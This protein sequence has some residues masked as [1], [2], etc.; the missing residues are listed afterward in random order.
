M[1][2]SYAYLSGITQA[3]I[4][5]DLVAILTGTT[6]TSLLSAGCDKP[7]TSILTTYAAAGWTVHDAAAG[8]NKQCLKA[9]CAHGAIDKYVT[10]D[11]NTAG[12]VIIRPYQTW[13]NVAHTGTG[14]SSATY[15]ASTYHQRYNTAGVG[16]MHISATAA[17]ILLFGVYAATSGSVSSADAFTGVIELS[18]MPWQTVASGLLPVILRPSST[19]ASTV[20][21]LP[22]KRADGTLITAPTTA[23][24]KDEGGVIDASNPSCYATLS[25]SGNKILMM[26][27]FRSILGGSLLAGQHFGDSSVADIYMVGQGV[28]RFD[29]FTDHQAKTRILFPFH[30][31]TQFAAVL[32]G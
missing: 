22:Y 11:T 4:L 1:Y 13:D 3:Q 17:K 8:V 20:A 6:D 32:K 28:N 24:L 5:A 23:A 9:T 19:T 12:F 15:D 29:E 2:A 25:A 31:A 14:P 26:Y 21:P 30:S 10:I 18:A 27:H 16:T 7:A